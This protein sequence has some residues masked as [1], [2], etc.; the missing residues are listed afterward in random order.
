M[1][2]FPSLLKKPLPF[3]ENRTQWDLP[4]LRGRSYALAVLRQPRH[5]KGL[6]AR[7]GSP[8]LLGPCGRAV[9]EAGSRGAGL[10]EHHQAPLQRLKA[11]EMKAD[12]T[13]A[14]AHG[15]GAGGCRRAS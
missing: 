12:V 4:R 3:K 6:E 11:A 8:S 13:R 15:Q 5:P 9:S 7:P 2:H 14:R 10:P 1:V